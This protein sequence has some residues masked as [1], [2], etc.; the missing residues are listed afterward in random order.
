MPYRLVTLVYCVRDDRVLLLQRRKPPYVGYWVA[1]GGKIERGESPQQCALREL[2]EETGL[3]ADDAQL[4]AVV[5][6]TSP[7]DDWQWMI[8]V[9]RASDVSGTILTQSPEGLL[10]WFDRDTEL[11]SAHIPP[12]D[13]YFMRDALRENA[14]VTEYHF[15]YDNNLQLLGGMP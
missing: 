4:R 9:Y 3:Y 15:D 1:P 6:E 12:A 5:T 14:G 2:R 13:R 8:F 7:R 11:D 10:R